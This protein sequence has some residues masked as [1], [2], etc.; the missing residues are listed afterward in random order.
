MGAT[1]KISRSVRRVD[2]SAGAGQTVFD[3]PHPLFDAQDLQVALKPTGSARFSAL[4]YPADFSVS[5][6]AVTRTAQVTLAT[7]PRATAGAPAVVV[8][9]RGLRTHERETDVCRGGVVVSS[10]LERE[11]DR[12]TVILQELRRDVDDIDAEAMRVQPG[13]TAPGIDVDALKGQAIGMSSAGDLVGFATL[14]DAASAASRAIRIAQGEVPITVS[15]AALEG[16]TLGVAG[17]TLEAV[18]T[19][20]R[21]RAALTAI[22]DVGPRALRLPEPVATL[23]AAGPRAGML[24]GFDAAGTPKFYPPAY[25]ASGLGPLPAM[26]ATPTLGAGYV[27]PANAT[28]T[29]N[30][31][32]DAATVQAAL[33]GTQWWLPSVGSELRIQIA[34]HRP[35]VADLGAYARDDGLPVTLAGP[36]P[37]PLTVT[38]INA[39]SGS[40]GARVLSVTFADVSALAVGDG[41]RMEAFSQSYPVSGSL[42]PGSAPRRGAL[43]YAYQAGAGNCQLTATRGSATVTFS[44]A[45]TTTECPVGSLL[46]IASYVRRV[47]DRPTTTTATLSATIETDLPAH[48]YW[49]ILAPEA[50]TVTVAA[51]VA[52][53]AGTAFLADLSPGDI[54]VFPDVDRVS[55]VQTVTSDTACAFENTFTIATAT[56]FAVIR[57]PWEL[58]GTWEVLTID[59]GTK[60][61][62]LKCPSWG[63]YAPPWRG[64]LPDSCYAIKAS[65]S[66]MGGGSGLVVNG[67][68]LTLD[69]LMIK[70]WTSAS[71]GVRA[72]GRSGGTG[73]LLFKNG[74]AVLGFTYGV[75]AEG[76]VIV[77]AAGAHFV[78]ASNSCLYITNGADGFLDDAVC[79]G[80]GIYGLLMDGGHCYA[81]RLN[82]CCN[83]EDGRR[84]ETGGSMYCDWGDCSSN[85]GRG[86]QCIGAISVHFVGNRW[87]LNGGVFAGAAGCNLQNGP[88]GRLSGGVALRNRGFGFD[89]T[90]A[91]AEMSY[92][93]AIGNYL[94]GFSAVGCGVLQLDRASAGLNYG[95]GVSLRMSETIGSR[96]TVRGNAGGWLVVLC[97]VDLSN[98]TATGNV[99]GSYKDVS[100]SAGGRAYVLGHHASSVFAPTKNTR[101]GGDTL[102]FDDAMTG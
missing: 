24:L 9:L 48:V 12:Q 28:I 97:T 1:L 30:V 51:G 49:S 2:Y 15:M 6:N 58:E 99:I 39:P 73:A 16:Q 27:M 90:S 21:V 45:V 63:E 23:A 40:K 32:G 80:G 3:F 100:C 11:L 25:A 88:R 102:I 61:A 96:T 33:I 83:R 41:V 19:S 77:E 55:A 89:L 47:V 62:T 74:A 87:I 26:A 84:I 69:A 93:T 31:P 101:G 92:A 13:Q 46:L 54:M 17:G 10:T 98:A 52:T 66:V 22:E 44:Q 94:G 82:T 81:S 5:I 65:L 76:P 59:V 95:I 67:S 57:R 38:S 86:D 43:N 34:D 4:S 50:G 71:T 64:M 75:R 53:G 14:A 91:P 35:A 56:S 79:Y 7:P 60:T 29:V 18:A 37:Q 85:G 8:R 42:L 20:S 68:R 70:G 72:N 36:P 78:G